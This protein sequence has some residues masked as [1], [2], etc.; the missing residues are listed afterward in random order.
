MIKNINIK[1][2]FPRKEIERGISKKATSPVLKLEKE[3]SM[4]KAFT[5]SEV[6]I[7]LLVVGIIAI[8]VLPAV[9]NHYRTRAW[10]TAQKT[11]EKRL[12]SAAYEMINLGKMDGYTTTSDFISELGKHITFT[13]IC[14]S[15]QLTE[16]FEN[17]FSVNGEM[18]NTSE[19]TEASALGNED[20]DTE[21][22]GFRTN[23]GVNGIMAYDSRCATSS[24]SRV[25]THSCLAYVIDT[26]D[27]K[28]PNTYNKDIRMLNVNFD[29]SE[30]GEEISEEMYNC[31]EEQG[32]TELLSL[33]KVADFGSDYSRIDC[34]EANL[35][36]SDYN[37]Y[38]GP[39]PSTSPN[40]QWAGAKKKCDKAGMILPDPYELRN[41]LHCNLIV[42]MA[43]QT[44]K[45]T[46]YWS[47][48]EGYDPPGTVGYNSLY[49]AYNVSWNAS[50]STIGLKYYPNE[51][52]GAMCFKY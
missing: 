25:Q 34:S 33:K 5:L 19:L 46:S 47:S 40:D 27:V 6:L 20:Y 16:C 32:Y 17:Q 26:N 30:Y 23:F 8:L 28:S 44:T 24:N 36:S 37:K 13:K 51:Q 4:Q 38:C 39:H 41:Y 15:N 22:V 43:S 2:S 14:G 10:N 50:I 31:F 11:F 42:N 49:H 45:S 35:S 12:E 29:S 9:T 18:I 1:F 21:V 3:I 52:R 48:T 7:T